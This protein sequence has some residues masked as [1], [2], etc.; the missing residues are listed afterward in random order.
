MNKHFKIILGIF[1]T[2]ILLIIAGL[3]LLDYSS[4]LLIKKHRSMRTDT[5]YELPKNSVDVLFVGSSKYLRSISPN[6][7]YAQ[8]G[9]SSYNR[10]SEL[11][12][13]Q[14][15]YLF[16]V[17]SFKTQNPKVVFLSTSTL[18]N[19]FNDN[20][21]EY[22][23]YLAM[24]KAKFS[25]DKYDVAIAISSENIKGVDSSAGLLFP[26][27]KYKDRRNSLIPRDRLTYSNINTLGFDPY[28]KIKLQP[29]HRK[30]FIGMIDTEAKVDV[31]YDPLVKE[32]LDKTIEFCKKNGAQV[33]ICDTP[34]KE[35]SEESYAA[36][37]ALAEEHGVIHLDCHIDENYQNIHEDV[38][39]DW[40]DNR[41]H[42]NGWGAYNVTTFIGQYL[43]QNF[44]FADYRD[45]SGDIADS[46]KNDYK[47]YY[48]RYHMFLPEELPIPENYALDNVA[49]MN[50]I[51]A[52]TSPT[53]KISNPSYT[54]F[55]QQL[56]KNGLE[57]TSEFIE[58]MG[59]GA[60]SV[61]RYKLTDGTNIIVAEYT[62][63]SENWVLPIHN[64]EL[65]FGESGKFPIVDPANETGM[66]MAFDGTKTKEQAKLL[67]NIYNSL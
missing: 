6:Q 30:N 56:S 54:T 10:S 11:I 3:W 16:V 46:L 32:Y 8:T 21:G 58:V 36:A 13:A 26:A 62:Y 64:K 23:Y 39:T 50:S 31:K 40:H 66:L 33:V 29:D 43:R 49:R 14:G 48:Y 38:Q 37:R 19:G 45:E 5:F 4:N 20:W 2:V 22:Y 24:A 34:S 44:R 27:F 59:S 17:D 1:I 67:V 47:E 28:W 63:E 9:I 55:E 57:Y 18:V 42:Q 61:K 51:P 35:W 12:P 25:K 53:S 15:Q 41:R 52:I 65:D 60:I 7:I